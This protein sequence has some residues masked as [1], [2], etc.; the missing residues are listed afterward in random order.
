ML[1]SPEGPGPGLGSAVARDAVRCVYVNRKSS[2]P[3][4]APTGISV[5]GPWD[6]YVSYE[7]F[8]TQCG[9]RFELSAETYYG[10]GG[11]WRVRR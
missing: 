2:A 10:S 6:D 7:L 4:L 1:I 3:H 11:A 9:A 5:D 8:S